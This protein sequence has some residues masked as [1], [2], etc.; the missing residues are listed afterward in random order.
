MTEYDY[1]EEGLRQYQGRM[2]EISRWAEVTAEI[3]QKE[4]E[5]PPTFASPIA[6]MCV[7]C[8]RSK[9]RTRSSDRG[10]RDRERERSPSPLTIYIP[11]SMPYSWGIPHS[12]TS[13]PQSDIYD[14]QVQPHGRRRSR[15][16]NRDERY[17]EPEGIPS[18]PIL[19]PTP[20]G[21]G[22]PH[23]FTSPP[24]SD[25]YDVQVQ[26]HGRRRSRSSNRDERYREPEG[27]PSP[28]IL[29]PTPHGWGIPH[30][31]TSPPQNDIYDV[32]VQPHGRRR[33]RS[34]N[35]DERY[36]E[37]EGIPSPPILLPTPHGWGIPH[38]F[39]SP[40]QSDIY[41]VQV[42]PH[43][44]R[45]SRSSDRDERYR[46]TPSPP[47]PHGW[48]IPHS[49]TLPP[50][51]DIYD[52]QVQPRGRRRSRSS[53]WDERYREPER[54]PSPPTP[55]GWGVPHS[56]T[57]SPRSDIHDVQVQPRGRRRSR[58]SDW[59]ERYREPERT[60]SPPILLP[61]PHGWGI[62]HSFSSSPRSDI[63]DVQVQPHGRRRSRSSDRDERDRERERAQSP[64]VIYIPP[65]MPY[66]WGIP[67]S[68]T[69]PPWGDIYAVQAQPHGRRR[70]RSSD[71]DERER[72][73][74]PPTPPS[75]P[76]GWGIPYPITSPPG[77]VQVPPWGNI[78]DVQVQPPPQSPLRQDGRDIPHSFDVY[79][80]NPPHPVPTYFLPGRMQVPYPMPQPP[81]P[82]QQQMPL[83]MQMYHLQPQPPLIQTHA[84]EPP[85]IGETE[86]RIWPHSSRDF[87]VLHTIHGGPWLEIHRNFASYILY[88]LELYNGL[89]NEIIQLSKEWGQWDYLTSL[90][91]YR[92][93]VQI[94]LGY[95]PK[96]LNLNRASAMDIR[97]Q[98]SA[99]LCCVLRQ[100][101]SILS[102]RTTYKHFLTCRG[103]VAQRLLDLLQELLDSPHEPRLRAPFHKA[104]FSKALSRLSSKCGLHP[105]CF[106][107]TGLEK[108]SRQVAG[109]GFGDI[110]K[111][112][113][114][115]QTV[116]VK[117]MRQF[118]DDDMKASLK[119]LG[120]E[121]LIWRQLSHP[122]LLPFFGLYK[123]ED[124]LCLI[125]PWM[126]NGDL[127]L[128][129]STAP[130]DIDRVSLIAD[131]A[132]G[133]E[134][135][136]SEHIVHG[137][138][139]TPNILVTP[140][141]RACIADFGLSTIVDELSLKM[142]FSSRSGRA[143]TVR[144][145]APELLKNES[146]DHYGSDVYA[147]GCVS[148][149]ILTGKIPFFELANEVAI[150]LKVIEGIRPSR[151]EIIPSELWLLLD[152]CW[153][154]ETV[155]RPIIAAI[156]QRLSRQ[157]IGKEEKQAPP[158]WDD[159]Y[160]ARFRRFV[161]EWPLLPSVDDIQRRILSNPTTVDV[162]ALP[163]QPQNYP[164]PHN[165]QYPQLSVVYQG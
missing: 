127:R 40:P 74:S 66:S 64:L 37:P 6:C 1:S 39:T 154:Q 5:A 16:S 121:A 58:S 82:Q 71:W 106:T 149:E 92:I 44:R 116:A 120:R 77:G 98:I 18:P 11:P 4:P 53:D 122:N 151:L 20:H 78:Y 161:Q 28:P 133:L 12:F 125:S 22:I 134:Y 136:H 95:L 81:P 114:G 148:Y 124:R 112:L 109:G 72:A 17:R 155:E 115:G 62:P 60:P 41:D 105:T 152:D 50:R 80:V 163:Q 113:V 162:S 160:S 146:S 135:L 85:A 2:R 164:G 48:G 93:V 145:Q 55:H 43:G 102:N 24:Q 51:S 31:F 89:S 32:Q 137:D 88:I 61:T 7:L 10:G 15:S 131:V 101:N 142:T 110:Y 94:L 63:Y 27:I 99:D 156:S 97:N 47:T 73:S 147:F 138:L 33:S 68:F 34:S 9:R 140:S 3:P 30:S 65:S 118:A 57:S 35:R 42:Q 165:S 84:L 38:S 83:P 36:R 130:P 159:A 56:F 143:G 45:R 144:Y 141:G 76:Q 90:A 49:F 158:D 119:K 104:L 108:I 128:F 126:E 139:K 13:P 132:M 67:H 19:L 23:S 8:L 52:V 25:I 29:L 46:E 103:A 123:L 107:L 14:V 129:L 70:S 54:T 69:P 21:W 96:S 79:G 87:R 153:H 75:M 59:D 150:I 157:L 91:N 100:M 117:S 111:G 86:G 26:P